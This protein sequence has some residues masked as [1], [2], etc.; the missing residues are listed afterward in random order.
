[1]GNNGSSNRSSN[2][3]NFRANYQTCTN[4]KGSGLNTHCY[5]SGASQ[6]SVYSG[7]NI[8]GEAIQAALCRA[9]PT[10]NACYAQGAADHTKGH[11]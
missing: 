2:A 5:N 8:G 3:S 11:K 9:T 4:P 1:M 6:T 10:A 7:P